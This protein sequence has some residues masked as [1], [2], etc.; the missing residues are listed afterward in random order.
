MTASAPRPEVR[1]LAPGE[2]EVV[3]AGRRS[4]VLV[5]AGVGVPGL[6]EPDLVALVVEVLLERESTLP[7]VLDLSHLLG[8]EPGLWDELDRRA[9]ELD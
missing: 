8:T 1:A 5:P 4:R 7:E 6:D 3:H 9:D 2:H